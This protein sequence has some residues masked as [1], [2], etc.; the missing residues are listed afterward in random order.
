MKEQL[1]NSLENFFAEINTDAAFLLKIHPESAETEVLITFP[2]GL[3][4]R[5]H[6]FPIAATPSRA[7]VLERNREKLAALLPVSLLMILPSSPRAALFVRIDSEEH[8]VLLIWCS[9]DPPD[10]VESRILIQKEMI[11][12]SRIL[13][14]DRDAE[15]LL[16]GFGVTFSVIKQAIVIIDHIRLRAT[17]NQAA[18]SLLDLPAERVSLRVLSEALGK[19]QDRVT[20]KA[21]VQEIIT[22]LNMNPQAIIKDSI[23]KFAGE[24]SHLRVSSWFFDRNMISGRIWVFDDVSEIMAALEMSEKARQAEAIALKQSQLSEKRLRLATDLAGLGTFTLNFDDNTIACDKRIGEIIQHPETV[25][26]TAIPFDCWMSQLHPDDAERTR[27]LIQ[28]VRINNSAYHNEYRIILPDGSLRYIQ[29]N[30]IIEHNAHGLQERLF[31]VHQDITGLKRNE[32]ALNTLWMAIQQSPVSVV[33]TDI[34]TVIQYV[35]PNFTEVTGYTSADVVGKKTNILKSGLTEISVFESLWSTLLNGQGWSGEFINRRKNGELF[36]EEAY[37]SPVFDSNHNAVQ[38]VA[39]K[40]DITA[41]K[42]QGRELQEIYANLSTAYNVIQD[43]SNE[44]EALYNGLTDIVLIADIETK[45]IMGCNAVAQKALS[46][47][48]DELM[49]HTVE[50]L[51]PQDILE[52]TVTAFKLCAQGLQNVAET[53]LLDRKGNRIPVSIKASRIVYKGSPCLM[54]VMRDISESKRYEAQMQENLQLK[55]D[56]IS[57]I[58]HELRT[59]LFSILGFSSLLLKDHAT[60]DTE[61]RQEFLRIVH[62]ESRRLSGLIENMLTISRIDSGHGK[63]QPIVFDPAPVVSEIVRTLRRSAEEKGLQL[64]EELSPAPLSVCFDKDAFKQV[65]LNLIDNAIKYTPAGGSVDVRLCLQEGEVVIEVADDGNGI[66]AED[67]EKIF[68]KFYRSKHSANYGQGT[69]LGLAIVKEIVELHG[70]SVS[71]SST[72]HDGSRFRVKMPVN[73]SLAP[74]PR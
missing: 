13:E 31:G 51:I 45:K 26:S 43:K 64:K 21:A 67:L 49:A 74:E 57:T 15:A 12:L 48:A 17:V 8:C 27:T 73:S 55:N 72:L 33:I 1:F 19:L 34:D 59:P 16:T 65:L 61:N 58:S 62:D 5:R 2:C 63:Y 37:I 25:P 29:S 52:E 23:W 7:L 28:D 70:G 56:F 20:N 38:Y 44:L 32:V 39:V 9:V 6:R 68:E 36:Y 53:A 14:H 35:N 22:C 40:L 30:G 41:R 11:S 54:G 60:F 42:M 10:D 18:I 3:L 24:P 69:G 50:S 71:V 4:E 47:S 46:W 66:P